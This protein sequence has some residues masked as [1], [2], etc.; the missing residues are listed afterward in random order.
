MRGRA[1]GSS[2]KASGQCP[3]EL[4]GAHAG[5]LSLEMLHH[6]QLFTGELV[7]VSGERALEILPRLSKELGVFRCLACQFPHHVLAQ[8]PSTLMNGTDIITAS[9]YREPVLQAYPKA[10]ERS[11]AERKLVV[12]TYVHGEER[13]L[14]CA[15]AERYYAVR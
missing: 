10:F 13:V 5:C 7:T 1:A 11:D 2:F 4:F 8:D 9:V 12:L 3:G 15:P 6:P 14:G